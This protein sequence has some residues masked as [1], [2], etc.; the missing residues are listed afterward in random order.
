M[1]FAPPVLRFTLTSEPFGLASSESQSPGKTS[2]LNQALSECGH[3][4]LSSY[5]QC[6]NEV[7]RPGHLSPSLLSL[8][9]NCIAK[10]P[11][12]VL[13]TTSPPL[14]PSFSP[15]LPLSLKIINK[16]YYKIKKLN[17]KVMHAISN[18]K[19]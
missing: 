14:S 7:R 6:G 18:F 5:N 2:S 8:S 10:P 17:M 16:I 11:I 3:C 9:P 19:I 15:S 12:S 13:P 4:V 1:N